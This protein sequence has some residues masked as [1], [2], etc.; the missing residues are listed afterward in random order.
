MRQIKYK[1]IVH[2]VLNDAPFIGAIVIADHCSM[3]CKNCINEHLK[4][5][6]YRRQH[7]AAQIIAKVK[8]NGLD[9]GVIFSGLEWS[10]Q[11]DDLVEL[12]EVA[13]AEDL[14]VIVYTHCDEEAFFKIAPRLKDKPIYIKFGLYDKK[15][16]TDSHFSHGVKLATSNQYIKYFG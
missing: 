4:S 14:K 8:S 13:L 9:E 12:V 1:G 10:E 6:A 2:N 3:P 16:R 11:P 15:L 7:S 5:D